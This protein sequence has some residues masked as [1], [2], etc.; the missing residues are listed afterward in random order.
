MQPPKSVAQRRYMHARLPCL[1]K[2]WEEETPTGSRLPRK[3]TK[4]SRP[5]KR[6]K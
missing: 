4:K 5:R 3:V 6:G 2:Q 1:V